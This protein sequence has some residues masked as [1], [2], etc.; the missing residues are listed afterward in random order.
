MGKR[1]GIEVGVGGLEKA[2]GGGDCDL[3]NPY[4]ITYVIKKHRKIIQGRESCSGSRDF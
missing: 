3:R 2:T 1:K 4:Y